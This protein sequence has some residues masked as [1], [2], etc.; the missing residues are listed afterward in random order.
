MGQQL[1][2][3]GHPWEQVRQRDRRAF[4]ALIT[5]EVL[6]AALDPATVP[7]GTRPLNRITLIWLELASAP[8]T[9]LD[10]KA[11]LNHTIDQI[12]HGPFALHH[13]CRDASVRLAAMDEQRRFHRVLPGGRACQE[14]I[15]ALRCFYKNEGAGPRVILTV[16]GR[17][18]P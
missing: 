11:G 15:L 14:W 12:E 13:P 18:I 5:G 3:G 8:H 10:F 4:A 17:G 16:G 9:A 1:E 6:S 2:P 7:L